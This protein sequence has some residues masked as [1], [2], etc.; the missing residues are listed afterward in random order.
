VQLSDTNNAIL[1]KARAKNVELGQM[2]MNGKNEKTQSELELEQLER[3]ILETRALSGKEMRRKENTEKELQELQATVGANQR[4]IESR[5]E[6]MIRCKKELT[7][8][9]VKMQKS[10]DEVDVHRK[11]FEKFHE[12]SQRLQ[13]D[14]RDAQQV[15]DGAARTLKKQTNEL[16]EINT[17]IEQQR[18]I[19]ARK[20]AQAEKARAELHELE[21]EKADCEDEKIAKFE[22]KRRLQ[23]AVTQMQIKLHNTEKQIDTCTREREVLSQN[24]MMKVDSIRKKELGL[25]IRQS[26]VKN[27][28][29]EHQV[30]RMCVCMYRVACEH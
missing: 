28:K 2:D 26:T 29:N 17:H 20:R 23:S 22:L 5:R 1:A 19:V 15:Y 14:L 3:K 21:R 12:K 10:E 24:H 16:N 7:D 27:I 8:A 9:E 6:E 4:E 13:H 18:D 25:K 30:R 11:Q